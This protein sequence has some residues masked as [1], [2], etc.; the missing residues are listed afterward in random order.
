MASNAVTISYHNPYMCVFAG[1]VSWSKA[2]GIKEAFQF[3]IHPGL[4]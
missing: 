4:S 2:Y 1:G 3:Q